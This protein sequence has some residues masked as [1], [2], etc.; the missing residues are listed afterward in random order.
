MET[1]T[2][3]DLN[4]QFAKI[5]NKF[6]SIVN[7]DIARHAGITSRKLSDRY[8]SS[9]QTVV[10]SGDIWGGTFTFQ[11][12][13]AQGSV[14]EAKIYPEFPGKR[15]YL[16]AVSIRA[17]GYTA[18][19]DSDARV[20]ITLDGVVINSRDITATGVYYIRGGSGASAFSSP[21]A[22]LQSGSY[23]GIQLGKVESGASGNVATATAVTITLSYKVELTS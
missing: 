4:A 12:I 19:S 20:W 23:I 17:D 11:D 13:S 3:A 9:Y 22:A 18:A 14:L 5:E 7:S 10:L 15:A 21:I 2:S 16:C 6:G 8:C 1:L